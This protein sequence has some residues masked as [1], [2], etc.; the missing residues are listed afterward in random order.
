MTIEEGTENVPPDGKYYVFK[1]GKIVG[2]FRSFKTAQPLYKQLVE[3]QNLPPL[4]IDNTP[5]STQ[6]MIMDDWAL[7]SNK[8]LLSKDGDNSGKKSG[9]FHK[10][11]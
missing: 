1:N 8:S 4:P 5:K 2:K 10:T 7:K 11:R 3:E 9:R 6:Q